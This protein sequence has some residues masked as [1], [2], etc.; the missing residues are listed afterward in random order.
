MNTNLKRLLRR[1]SRRLRHLRALDAFQ[2][3][4]MLCSLV[5]AGWMI[6]SFLLPV[7]YLGERIAVC[8]LAM[9]AL[10]CIGAC[11]WPVSVHLSARRADECGLQERIRTAVELT[12]NSDMERLQIADAENALTALDLHRSMPAR[13]RKWPLIIALVLMIGC[14]VMAVLPNPQ[15]AIL[16]EREDYRRQ[17]AEQ[18]ER[19]DAMAES[20][21]AMDLDEAEAIELRKLL[22][23]LSREL[24]E[25]EDRREALSTLDETRTALEKLRRSAVKTAAEALSQ[26]NMESIAQVM[27]QGDAEAVEA[28]IQ[29]VMESGDAEALAEALD[30]AAT[31]AEQSGD[32]ALSD[33]LNALSQAVASGQVSAAQAQNLAKAVNAGSITN[34]Q[35]LINSMKAAAQSSQGNSASGQSGSGQKGEGSG[36]KSGSGQGAGGQGEGGGGGAGKGSTNQDQGISAEKGP[37]NSSGGSGY[38]YKMGEYEQIYDP[39][40]LGD[41]GEAS[42]V[43]GEVREG[44][45]QQ[46]DLGPGAGD[47]SGY[48][49]YDQVIGEYADAAANAANSDNLPEAA[50]KWVNDYF[51]AL[52]E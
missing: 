44:E 28:A 34:A 10:S 7:A 33:A 20:M 16:R 15:D 25:T 4:L 18:A 46:I 48:V 26:A 27:G 47:L 17:M 36:G 51:G 24:R 1:V 42:Q 8:A 12:G 14:G 13:L 40:R 31:Q 29:E 35:A 45:D 9:L 32:A 5:A 21:E 30:A 2:W 23:D 39:T 3:T 38:G 50:K 11:V 19:A 41:G 6:A 43:S 37:S 49:P 52:T 22:T